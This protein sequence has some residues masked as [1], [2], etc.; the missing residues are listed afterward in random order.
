M[1][2]GHPW[3]EWLEIGDS[4]LDND[5][6]LQ[7]RLVSALVD[8]LEEGRPWLAQRLASHLRD[9]SIVHFEVEEGR[10]RREQY[11]GLV[12]H[13]REHDLLL[14]RMDEIVDAVERE[15]DAM[16]I[17]AT[18]DFRSALANHIAT[19]DRRLVSKPTIVDEESTPIYA[20]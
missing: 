16:A 13:R 12:E 4:D 11:P 10:M 5:H 7:M 2:E 9:G 3:S 15:D 19:S 18:I 8:A 6:H 14:S 17:A 20:S 1:T